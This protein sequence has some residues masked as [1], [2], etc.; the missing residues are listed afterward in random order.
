MSQQSQKV[1]LMRAFNK[2]FYDFMD[3]IMS[4]FDDKSV[5]IN[6]KKKCEMIQSANPAILVRAWHQ[7]LYSKYA[8]VIDAGN[9]EFFLE[10][11]YSDDVSQF[12]YAEQIMTVINTFRQP[13]KD[14]SDSNKDMAMKHI[15]M[16]SRIS[17]KYTECA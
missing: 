1:T 16:L 10:K 6:A 15:Q 5:F 14:L 9:T 8:E 4:V 7:Y 3:D 2:C 11:D 12:D 17:Q 13:L